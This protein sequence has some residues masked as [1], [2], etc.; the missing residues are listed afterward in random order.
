M[1]RLVVARP[2]EDERPDQ[3]VPPRRARL[4]R[5]VQLARGVEERNDLVDAVEVDGTLLGGLELSLAG[6]DPNWVARDQVVLDGDLEDLPEAGDRLVDRLGRKRRLVDLASAV[7]VDLDDRDLR[8][9]MPGEERQQVIAQLPLVVEH[10][11]GCPLAA[12]SVEP[13]AGEPVE[14]WIGLDVNLKR[15]SRRAPDPSPNVGQDVL[16]LVFG[17]RPVPPFF[18]GS[19]RLVAALPVRRESERV[20][21]PAPGPLLDDRPSRRSGHQLG[22]GCMGRR[23]AS[24]RVLRAVLASSVMVEAR[25]RPPRVGPIGSSSTGWRAPLGS[26]PRRLILAGLKLAQARLYLVRAKP[27]TCLRPRAHA[28]T[29][30]IARVLVHPSAAQAVLL[31]NFGGRKKRGLET[32]QRLKFLR[33]E[34][35]EAAKLGIR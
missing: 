1:P 9:P 22:G 4:G 6:V 17:V 18:G 35:R 11:V 31:G 3:R 30:E 20:G 19:E 7:A 26:E 28:L 10:G 15:R 2:G 33:D 5:Q 16:Q 25:R 32:L 34:S 12:V 8:Q 27:E 23:G 24:H 29:T 21:R 14:R 13:L